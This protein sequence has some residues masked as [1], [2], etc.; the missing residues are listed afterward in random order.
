MIQ[1]LNNMT[2]AP[3]GLV[4]LR[5]EALLEDPR[6]ACCCP[7]E[8][9]IS[10]RTTVFLYSDAH[11]VY[12]ESLDGLVL[13][14]VSADKDLTQREIFLL[15][16]PVTLNPGVLYCLNSLH[17]GAC[18]VRRVQ[19]DSAVF[20]TVN[21]PDGGMEPFILPKV[22]INKIYTLFYQEQEKG[23]LFKGECHNFWELTYVD[24]GYLHM[25]LD[26]EK[27][28]LQQSEIMFYAPGQHHVQY[29]DKDVAVCYV[30]I[31]FDMELEDEA[32]LLN[33]K[34]SADN[35]LTSL[36]DKILYEKEH[37]IF[38]SEDL[39]ACYLK[40]F[41]ILLIRAHEMKASQVTLNTSY[42]AN[43]EN[44]LV[45]QASKYIDQN[46]A[47]H[48]SVREIASHVNV[49]QSYLSVLFKKH[50]MCTMTEYMNRARQE[51]SKELIREG[52]HS[53]TEI[54]SL[55]GYTSVHYF[56]RQFKAFVGIS[57]TEYAK[58]L[59]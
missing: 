49:S 39:I 2:F 41:V 58:T 34:F 15:D 38:Y 59:R 36:L 47:K 40:E 20:N 22:N 13:L 5:S 46:I 35:N 31:S 1:L 10:E 55:L 45:G 51:R 33:R 43:L 54:S 24:K 28:L 12:L 29:A 53:I 42:K 30:T 37:S 19:A 25:S 6:L 57:P 56:S 48:L 7:E 11:P 8:L 4:G 27:L 16:K 26:G 44:T 3:Y 9:L 23:F 17:G 32:Q 52:K 18:R 50:K 14:L 21:A